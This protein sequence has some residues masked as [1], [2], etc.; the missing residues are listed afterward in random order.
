MGENGIEIYTFRCEAS[1]LEDGD[2]DKREAGEG[3]GEGVV[4]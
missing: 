4:E 2:G 3:R 1:E